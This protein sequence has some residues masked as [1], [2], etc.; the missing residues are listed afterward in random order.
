MMPEEN[1]PPD[2]VGFLEKISEKFPELRS[3]YERVLGSLR[4]HEQQTEASFQRIEQELQEQRRSD[5]V[6]LEILR[7]QQAARAQVL[8]EI[9]SEWSA[10]R[11]ELRLIVDA[12]SHQ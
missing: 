11:E 12:Y 2:I 4:D 6:R 5:S 8:A 1:I 10:H 7:S 9:A 3:K